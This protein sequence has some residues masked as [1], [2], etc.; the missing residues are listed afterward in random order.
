MTTDTK[1][2]SLNDAA[3]RIGINLRSLQR[4]LADGTGPATVQLTARRIGVL[5]GDLARWLQSRK[6][7]HVDA[8]EDAS[9]P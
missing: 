9:R 8:P 4:L 7:G 2:L 6:R 5:E 1:V 3:N